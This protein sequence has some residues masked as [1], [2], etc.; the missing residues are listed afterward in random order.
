MYVFSTFPDY[1]AI[2]KQISI[3]QRQLVPYYNSVVKRE[4]LLLSLQQS[5]YIYISP[6]SSHGNKIL[7]VRLTAALESCEIVA[8]VIQSDNELGRHKR[9]PTTNLSRTHTP[10]VNATSTSIVNEM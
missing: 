9:F 6:F 2:R 10:Y 5:I 8:T 3:S 1:C 4:K 7:W